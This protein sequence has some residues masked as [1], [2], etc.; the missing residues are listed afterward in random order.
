[1]RITA[2]M[3]ISALAV[4]E[5]PKATVVHDE[6]NSCQHSEFGGC[7]FKIVPISRWPGTTACSFACSIG[8]NTSRLAKTLERNRICVT[9]GNLSCRNGAVKDD[10]SKRLADSSASDRGTTLLVAQHVKCRLL[11]SPRLPWRSTW[12]ERSA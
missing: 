9:N 4:P 7:K 1:M 12:A 8:D 2:A 6:S 10:A 3:E 5:R 11:N